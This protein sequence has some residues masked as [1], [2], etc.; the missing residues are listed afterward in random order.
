MKEIK[1]IYRNEFGLG[2]YWIQSGKLLETKVQLVFR[3]MGFYLSLAELQSF[4]D[5]VLPVLAP[6]QCSGCPEAQK[7]RSILV[8]TPDKRVDIV[9]STDELH[10]LKDLL[11]GVRFHISLDSY[12]NNLSL[13]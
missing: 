3:D 8:R 10:Q 12:L 5:L 2:F 6:Q 4:V 13:N 9:V 7:C 1:L 11:N